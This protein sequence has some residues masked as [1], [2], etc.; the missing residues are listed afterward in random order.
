VYNSCSSVSAGGWSCP[1]TTDDPNPGSDTPTWNA[2]TQTLT[3]NAAARDTSGA[4]AWFTPTAALKTLTITYQQRSGFPVYQTWFAEATTTITGTA[5]IDGEAY[6]GATV[7]ATDAAGTV[8]TTTTDSTGAYTFPAVVAA[9]GSAWNIEIV[10]PPGSLY[11][12]AQ[13]P[14]TGGTETQAITLD[15]AGST[16]PAFAFTTPPNTA[17]IIGTVETTGGDAVPGEPVTVAPGDGS[18]AVETESNPGGTYVVSDIPADQTTTIS[19]PGP[20]GGAP[21][22]TTVDV[23]ADPTGPVHAEAL[24]APSATLGSIDVTA[25]FTSGT[26]GPVQNA[27]VTVTNADGEVVATVTTGTD[28]TISIPDLAPGDYTVAIEQPATATTPAPP[29]TVTVTGGVATPVAF[30]FAAPTPDVSVTGTGSVVDGNDQGVPDRT[31]TATS[32]SDPTDQ[33]T[34]TTTSDGTYELDGLSESTTYSV[35]VPDADPV[36]VTTTTAP[37]VA[38]PTIRVASTT[39]VS[40]PPTTPPATTPP[41]TTPPA[42]TTSSTGTGVG[43]G[44]LAYTGSNP[45]PTIIGGG[46]LLAAGIVFLVARAVRGRRERDR[47]RDLD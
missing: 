45:G 14:A 10:A 47:L 6:P 24:Q 46:L 29:Q 42:T 9:G 11:N 33:I 31:V 19:I 38:I 34:A 4:S 30:T 43:T 32:E 44:D 12:G 5:T 26:P 21:V 16:V 35:S 22:T 41:S 18:P 25:S 20:T 1:K 7:T 17:T 36:T 40:P 8:F 39:P 3:G 37:T 27:A 15:A 13:V 23:P 2:A 28:G